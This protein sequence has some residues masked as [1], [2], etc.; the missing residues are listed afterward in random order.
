VLPDS[1]DVTVQLLTAD[2]PA[3]VTSDGQTGLPVI[4]GDR[5]H[6]EKSEKTF[7]IFRPKDRDY[8][9]TLRDK[10]KWSGR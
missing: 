9:Q 5:V 7:N 8:F 1:V 6:I 3:M 2:Q 10:L 4:G